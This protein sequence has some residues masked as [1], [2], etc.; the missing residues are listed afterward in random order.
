MLRPDWQG[1]IDYKKGLYYSN[2][3]NR[4]QENIKDNIKDNINDI[5]ND[6]IN[7]T[8][9]NSINKSITN[10][11][12]NNINLNIPYYNENF[13]YLQNNTLTTK[14]NYENF[15]NLTDRIS[16]ISRYLL[17]GND[18]YKLYIS[19]NANKYFANDNIINE[20]VANTDTTNTNT[21]TNTN[22]I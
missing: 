3:K 17:K 13:E 9:N 4:L 8:K 22:N 12:N 20:E 5:T 1:S 11:I 2:P 14:D 6:S 10:N 19:K 21:N 16:F 7:N 15:Y 18:Y